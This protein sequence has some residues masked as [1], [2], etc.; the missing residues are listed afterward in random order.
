M[1]KLLILLFVL[2]LTFALLVGCD[3]QTTENPQDDVTDSPT[4]KP[5]DDSEDEPIARRLDTPIVTISDDGLATWD[6][7]DGAIYYSVAI[8]TSESFVEYRQSANDFQLKDG[9]AIRVM[10]LGNGTTTLDSHYSKEKIYTSVIPTE[11][12]PLADMAS[13]PFN[14]LYLVKGIV[15]AAGES[16]LLLTD[17]DSSFLYVY[18]EEPHGYDVGDEVSFI[19]TKSEYW[20]VYELVGIRSS[21]LISTD[22]DIQTP[23]VIEGNGEYFEGAMNDFNVGECVTVTGRLTIS[24]E[25]YNFEVDGLNSALLSLAYNGEPLEDGKLYTVTGYLA[26]ISGSTNKYINLIVT[27]IV[28]V[29]DG[30]EDQ[31]CPTCY[32]SITSGDHSAL[33]CGHKACED[34]NHAKCEACE[35]YLCL[36]GDHSALPCGHKACEDGEHTLCQCGNYLCIGEH[37]GLACMERSTF[38]EIYEGENDQIFCT[39]GTVCADGYYEFMLT[40]NEGRYL[41]VPTDVLQIGRAHV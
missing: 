40:D 17:N 2:G 29:D 34:G 15:C 24:G 39:V 1:K 30:G 5:D 8:G 28:P 21:E 32:K 38:A 23:F 19:G 33:D 12:T 6:P 13:V 10:A 31:I 4:D 35:N 25:Y 9:D 41:H 20:N 18:T 14:K 7:I 36:G 37:S 16:N 3:R 27:E 26:F 22:N 11:L